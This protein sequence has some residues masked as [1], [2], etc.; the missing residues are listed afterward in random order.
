MLFNKYKI[1]RQKENGRL[2][3]VG[4]IHGCLTELKML[5]SKLE[6][7]FESDQMIFLG[8]LADRGSHNFETIQYVLSHDCFHL[9]AGNHEELFVAH[10]LEHDIIPKDMTEFWQREEGAWVHQYP[11]EDITAAVNAL[12]QTACYII[13]AHAIDGTKFGLTHAGFDCATWY[14]FQSQEDY[15]EVFYRR[16]MW[17]RDSAES[18]PNSLAPIENID[19]TF[20]GHTVFPKPTQN[21]SCVFID[22]GCFRGGNLTAVELNKFALAPTLGSHCVFQQKKLA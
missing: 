4:D 1:V 21:G 16:L 17:V 20:H 10:V 19:F 14:N 2:F 22:T 12:R 7:N 18:E 13:E 6:F 9:V 11:R 8:D 5:L 3:A 15:D